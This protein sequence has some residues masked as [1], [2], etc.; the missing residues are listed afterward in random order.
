[1][2]KD[3]Q[4]SKLQSRFEELVSDDEVK[5]ILGSIGASD[6][7]KSQAINALFSALEGGLDSSKKYK[8]LGNMLGHSPK[9]VKFALDNVRAVR[10]SRV[11]LHIDLPGPPADYSKR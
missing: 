5:N 8:I 11:A 1:M 9:M 7:N 3:R 6:L 2:G 4:K 10:E